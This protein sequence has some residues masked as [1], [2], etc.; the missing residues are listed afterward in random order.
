MPGGVLIGIAHV[1]HDGI[2]PGVL[3]RAHVP[4]ADAVGHIVCS[5]VMK[6]H[7]RRA[8]TLPH[9]TM[10][11]AL[12]LRTLAVDGYGNGRCLRWSRS[13]VVNMPSNA[14]PGVLRSCWIRVAGSSGVGG[15]YRKYRSP[16]GD[17]RRR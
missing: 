8:G 16:A 4:R 6:A 1:N 17:A 14:R 15:P 11:Y 10:R 3:S 7:E 2:R 12:R 9:R 5:F 13:I